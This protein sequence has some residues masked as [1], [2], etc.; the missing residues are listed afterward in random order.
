MRFIV[1]LRNDTLALREQHP[2]DRP[3]GRPVDGAA[4]C[5]LVPAP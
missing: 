5:G 2:I 3:W 1:E 4:A